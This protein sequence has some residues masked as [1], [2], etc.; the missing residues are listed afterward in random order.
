VLSEAGG[1]L[2]DSHGVDNGGD[3]RQTRGVDCGHCGYIELV[4]AARFLAGQELRYDLRCRL[5]GHRS[6]GLIDWDAVMEFIR[7]G[8]AY[9]AV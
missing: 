8:A 3:R 7:K 4:Y 5:R 1:H 6:M 9:G 2:A